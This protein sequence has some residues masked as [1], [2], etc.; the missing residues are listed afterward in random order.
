MGFLELRVQRGG[1]SN[2]GKGVLPLDGPRPLAFKAPDIF[3]P[4]IARI[5]QFYSNVGHGLHG[6]LAREWGGNWR[7]ELI[8][9]FETSKPLDYRS[10]I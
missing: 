7:V 4:I 1:A 8:T 10:A 2:G 6:M 5:V 3:A 9:R